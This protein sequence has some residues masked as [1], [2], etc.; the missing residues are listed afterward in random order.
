MV[1]PDPV[2][3]FRAEGEVV[4]LEACSGCAR[5][6]VAAVDMARRFAAWAAE[7]ADMKY[8]NQIR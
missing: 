8:A 1:V 2:E 6:D 4:D 7:K 5:G 3:L